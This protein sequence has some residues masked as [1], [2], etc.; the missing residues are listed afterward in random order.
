MVGNVELKIR[1][2]EEIHPGGKACRGHQYRGRQ[3]VEEVDQ[4]R[5]DREKEERIARSDVLVEQ[6]PQKKRREKRA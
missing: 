5:R 4:K 3:S 2:D 6:Q 1:R